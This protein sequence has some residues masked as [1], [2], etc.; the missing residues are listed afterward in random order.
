MQGLLLLIFLIG[1]LLMASVGAWTKA[2]FQWPGYVMLGL[3]GVVALVRLRK[4]AK[5][6]PSS[7][8][9][10]TALLF[11]VY[12]GVRAW[13]S[14]VEYL[15]RQDLMPLFGAF[16]AY[17]IFALHVEHPKL[18]KWFVLALFVLIAANFAIGFW[19]CQRD[20]TWHILFSLGYA[21]QAGPKDAGGF[22]HSENHLAGFLVLSSFLLLGWA[23]FAR[24][25]VPVR[26]AAMF[27]FI[28]A[29][30]ALA[31]T[32]SRGG[33]V[34]G[35]GGLAAFVVLSVI[36]YKKFLG[37][38]FW[39]YMAA[40]GTMF[41]ILGGFLVF[42]T[43]S[44]LEKAYKGQIVN[45]EMDFRSAL[46]QLAVKQWHLSP[47]VGTGAQSYE[48]YSRKL[49]ED[50]HSWNGAW[51]K[52]AI[53]AHNDY[54]QLLADYGAVGLGLGL[55]MAL[56]HGGNGLRFLFWYR[57]SRYDRTGDAT[58][59]S[60][61][62]AMGA[63]AGLV[64][65]GVQSIIDFNLH[66]PANAILAG[67]IFGLLAN[68]GFDSEAK[69]IVRVPGEKP[70]LT[71]LAAAMGGFILWGAWNGIPA[72]LAVERGWFKSYAK[73]WLGALPD[74]E[75]AVTRD[76]KNPETWFKYGRAYFNLAHEDDMPAAVTRAWNIKAAEKFE[77]ARALYPQNPYY[78][79]SLAEVLSEL[80]NYDDSRR[81]YE[82]SVEWAPGNTHMLSNYGFF[83]IKWGHY[84]EGRAVFDRLM[85]SKVW[86]NQD[87]VDAEQILRAL[88]EQEKAQKAAPAPV[89]PAA[90]P[91]PAAPAPVP[92]PSAPAAPAP[93]P[94]AGQ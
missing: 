77:K 74:Y 42:L 28:L 49:T 66:I 22:F 13:L 15:A 56:V 14:P 59:N 65:I 93:E 79:T 82:Q 37:P 5:F 50:M 83:L 73:D 31:M 3:A 8:C 70:L 19:Q 62:V 52:S 88:D 35:A 44:M 89:A 92:D 29:V 63:V 57:N 85:K 71:L 78:L 72:E 23:L 90:E 33:I 91:T 11:T 60:L 81:L 7:L 64:A 53:Y 51:D 16:C 75:K 9:L 86:W 36:L 24:T 67:S 12:C 20:R 54:A 47:V 18:R 55:L 32:H 25:K 80:G 87:R 30:V 84:A 10:L 26:M 40:F 39:K 27:G 69:R 68:P 2:A 41:L 76:P 38:Q 46:T 21:R 43:W 4:G 48:F 1:Y 17:T 6:T 58:S 94:K 34:A 45:D 61:A